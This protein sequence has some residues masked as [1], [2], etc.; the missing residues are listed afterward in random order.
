[1]EGDS[2]NVKDAYF[3][4]TDKFTGTFGAPHLLASKRIASEFRNIARDPPPTCS[5]TQSVQDSFLW[6]ATIMGPAGSPYSGGIFTLR[7]EFPLQYPFK[8]PKVRFD[9]KIYHCNITSNGG[10]CLGILGDDW[11]PALTIS[12]VLLSICSLLTNCN[13]ED[14]VVPS[15]AELYKNQREK[16]DT[17]A[18]E[19]T[20]KFAVPK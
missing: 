6:N 18:R 12:K 7:I 3:T 9:T 4:E 5:A 14:S 20:D 1:M 10:I 17:Y 2:A 19:W 8:P 13:P 16:H 15:I 11:S